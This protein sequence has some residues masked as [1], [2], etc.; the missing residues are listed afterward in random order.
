MFK[1]SVTAT[2]SLSS[3]ARPAC[4]PESTTLFRSGSANRAP[5]STVRDS[6]LSTITRPES[7]TG[8]SVSGRLS[9]RSD[10]RVLATESARMESART[11]EVSMES[12][13]VSIRSVRDCILAGSD[14][15]TSANSIN[16]AAVTPWRSRTSVRTE[17]ARRSRS[18][19][20]RACGGRRRTRANSAITATYDSSDIG[21]VSSSLAVRSPQPVRSERLSARKTCREIRVMR[22]RLDTGPGRVNERDCRAL[23]AG[24]ARARFE[25]IPPDDPVDFRSLTTVALA[26]S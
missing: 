12:A 8:V 16:S 19:W 3:A 26:C 24:M 15:A 2:E 25:S 11:V 20:P 14:P 21:V 6:E 22:Q 23:N 13:N 7:A 10:N 18:I 5:G 1:V 9:G 4:P 17:S